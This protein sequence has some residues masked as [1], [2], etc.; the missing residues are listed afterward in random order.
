MSD[1][2]EGGGTMSEDADGRGALGDARI[3]RRRVLAILGASAVTGAAAVAQQR[4]APQQPRQTHEAPNQPA[5]STQ[6]P[7]SQPRRR[8][9]T[10]GEYRAVRVLGD[11]VIPRDERSGSASDAGVPDFIDFHLS[12]P[13]TTA[14]VR[15]AWRGGLRWLDTESRRRFGVPYASAR[16]AQRHAILD[17]IAYADRVKPEHRYGHAFFNRFRDMCGAG[18]FSSAIGWQ[19]L[20]YMG[21]AFVPQWN[22]C[23]APALEKLG[24]SYALMD[25]RTPPK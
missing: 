17:D 16:P 20:K 12:V 6:Q 24:V 14:E 18:F 8:F 22:G 21:H 2:A 25:T 7:Q 23:P 9:L 1:D 13:E 15:L 3:S 19:D 10:A 4:P 11:D 5:T